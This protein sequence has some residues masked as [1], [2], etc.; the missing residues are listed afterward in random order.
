MNK[1]NKNVY[2]T[3]IILDWDDT[4]F[5]TSWTVQNGFDLTDKNNLTKYIQM[6]SV[7]D[8]HLYNLLK[9]LKKYGTVVIV[10]NASTKWI[11]I[12]STILPKTQQ[13]LLTEINTLSA[14]EMFQEQYPNDLTMWKKLIFEKITAEYFAGHNNQHIISIGD[15]EYEFLAL[16]DL[17]NE[18]SAMN[19]RLLKSIR[20]VKT[21]TFESLIDQIDVLSN[22]VDQILTNK[23]HMDLTFKNI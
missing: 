15:A 16:T 4:L 13:L 23:K 17:Y 9:K 14:R 5:P 11:K 21:P 3:L 22:S 7:L 10:T 19:K 20:F 2:K 18:M 1:Q 6:F 12:S 8:D